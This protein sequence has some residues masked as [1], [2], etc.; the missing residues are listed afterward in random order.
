M[1]VNERLFTAGTIEQF[2]SAARQRDRAAMIALLLA[3]ELDEQ[4]AAQTADTILLNP[5]QYSY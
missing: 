1:T 4:Q 2:D 5:R 3:V